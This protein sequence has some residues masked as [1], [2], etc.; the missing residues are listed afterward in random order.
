MDKRAVVQQIKAYLTEELEMHTQA[1]KAAH[2]AAT[3]DESRAEDQYDTRGLEASYLAGAQ[4]KRADEIRQLL[5]MYKYMPMRP[6]G[7]EDVVCAGALVELEFN[8]TRAYYYIAPQGG[9]LITRVDG[10][11][12]QVLTPNSPIGDAIAGHRVG[13]LI[14]VEVRDSVR[15][16]KI[17]SIS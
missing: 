10:Q 1:A 3:H 6:F 17:V 12:V 16:Y 5:L 14:E 9:G 15:E 2:E 4:A 13:D 8:K 11:P 7:P